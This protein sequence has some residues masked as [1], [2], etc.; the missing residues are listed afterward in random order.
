LSDDVEMGISS[1]GDVA[2]SD[3]GAGSSGAYLDDEPDAL[4]LP[5]EVDSK[6]SR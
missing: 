6:P 3:A 5:E 4:R 2:M 1:T